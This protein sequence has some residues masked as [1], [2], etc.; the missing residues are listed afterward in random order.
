M[1]K[2]S[3]KALIFIVRLHAHTSLPPNS[4]LSVR[5]EARQVQGEC[6]AGRGPHAE[7]C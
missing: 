5:T 3:V 4:V 6:A 1:S 2:V 7:V